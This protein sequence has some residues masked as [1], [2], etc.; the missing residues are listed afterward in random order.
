MR[1]DMWNQLKGLTADQLIRAL[2]RDGFQQDF[3][4][5]ATL[6]YVKKGPPRKRMV[7]HYHSGKQYGPKFLKGV[8]DDIGWTDDDLRRLRLIR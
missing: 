4:S 7:I 1:K 3:R 8:I 6:A 2:E 5:G